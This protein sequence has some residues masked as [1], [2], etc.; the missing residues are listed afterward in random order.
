MISD[1]LQ[2][3]L[4]P[5]IQAE[6]LL[7]RQRATAIAIGASSLFGL[8]YWIYHQ[9]TESG[10][11]AVTLLWLG[12]TA[13]LLIGAWAWANQRPAN[14]KAIARRLEAEY[15]ELDGAL[16]TAV[17]QDE[18]EGHQLSYLQERVVCEA[19]DHSVAHA[20]TQRYREE[21][22]KWASMF[23]GISLL[24]FIAVS[25]L[26][27]S[28]SPRSG[29]DALTPT[30]G[31]P[32][33]LATEISVTPG[34]TEV[35]KG[36]KL[37]VEARFEGVVPNEAAIELVSAESD[38]LLA[39]IPMKR[40]MEDP[41]YGAVIPN[42][43]EPV[44]Y[45]IAYPNEASETFDI[46]IYVHPELEN[47]DVTI[48]PPKY[49]KL[50]TKTLKDV[51]KV[52]ALE[53]S[54]LDF[55]F[56]INKEVSDAELFGEDGEIIPL[57]ADPEDP[58]RLT[59][60]FRPEK[61]KK[62]RLHLVDSDERA[63]KT[64][65]WFTVN[66]KKNQL[67]K[68]ELAFPGKDSEVSALE[69]MN[70]EGK[71]WD[72]LGIQR[73]GASITVGEES[74]EVVL[75]GEPLPGQK[76]H[77]FATL[78]ALE[79][80]GAEPTELVSYHFWAED[81]GPD[82]EPRRVESDMFFA[83]VR[84]WEHI[85]RE[86][87]QQGGQQQ[88]QQGQQSQSGQLRMQQKEIMNA[89]WKVARRA[90]LSGIAG[91]LEDVQVIKTAQETVATNVDMVLQQVQDPTLAETLKEAQAKMMEAVSF[92]DWVIQKSDGLRM[93]D[94]LAAEKSAYQ[95]LLKAESRES[96]VTRSQSSSSSGQSQ[97]Q[98]RQLMQLDLKE[99]ENRYET[100]RQ[101]Q[102]EQE[103][104][105]QQ[106]DLAVLNRLKELAR[107]EQALAEKIKE[108]EAALEEAKTE[109][110]RKELERQLE[111]LQEEQEELLRDVDDLMERM[112]SEENQERMGEER[113]KLAETR[114][115]IQEA[116][117]QLKNNELSEA[118][119]SATRAQQ[120]MD[121]LRE[122]F[123]QRTSQRFAEELRELRQQARDLADGQEEIGEQ[124]EDV[125]DPTNPFS[126]Q[127]SEFD[128][129]EVVQQLRDQKAE[130]QKLLE[131]MQQVSEQAEESE[132]VLSN[133][134][135]ETVRE[136]R[137]NGADEA[138]DEASTYTRYGNLTEAQKMEREAGRAIEKLKEGV[139]RAAET[140]LGDEA[141]ALRMA[142]NELD[143][144][145]QALEE[146]RQRRAGSDPN[147][148]EPGTS[149]D[150]EQQ[151]QNMEGTPNQPGQEGQQPGTDPQRGQQPGQGQQPSPEQ[152]AQNDRQPGKEPNAQGQGQQPQE[153]QEPSQGQ[154]PSD[155]PGQG[156]TQEG[157]QAGQGQGQMAENESGE[158]SDQ[159]G[160][161]FIKR[162]M[163]ESA[164][165]KGEQESQQ[166]GQQPGDGQQ[167]GQQGLQGQEGQ[168]QG[169]QGQSQMAQGQSGQQPGQGQSQGQQG[170]PGQ[171]Q[172]GQQPGTPQ[173]PQ[174]SQS[175]VAQGGG[176][177]GGGGSNFF[178]G[179]NWDDSVGGASNQ[180]APPLFFDQI[181]QA[182]DP[183][184]LMGEDY[185]AFADS[186]RKVEDVLE[187]PELRS[188]ASKVLDRARSMRI[189]YRRNDT[190][191]QWDVVSETII[192][193][194]V[195]LRDLVSEEL[196]RTEQDDSLVP[197]DR[198]P[199]PGPYRDLVRKYYEK[200]A[201]GE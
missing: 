198:D 56:K 11:A 53:G 6:K 183:G 167:P 100:E 123:R 135:Y 148:K 90:T 13:A 114:E 82:G 174:P 182:R 12:T 29:S 17:E 43:D 134:L 137:I 44:R 145:I 52:T 127:N 2:H 176:G 16:V 80:F 121:E 81:L 101:A 151:A 99:D 48:S 128:R 70:L 102:P 170:Q 64:P 157:E 150:Q 188:Q 5:L 115:K 31:S 23:Q 199:V 107:R 60:K 66:L 14:L 88:G 15:P 143:S 87:T 10:S 54:E 4:S 175:Q 117:E 28:V 172:G 185:E 108:I 160:K 92:L 104:T 33:G 149:P 58:T 158:E 1:I 169:E 41:A 113:E 38:E 89:T 46:G 147:A 91:Q 166:P 55:A 30:A 109:E 39:S 177:G 9:Q 98:Q 112:E 77:D 103:T 173:N 197:I 67:P 65:P 18:D 187:V 142:R 69:E 25:L 83:E 76:K 146:E 72:D 190:P 168:G 196:A 20:W 120:E 163:A 84:H 194:L 140:V 155:Q 35:E 3:R 111:R 186:L 74:R 95:L 59:A 125:P 126:E 180:T 171:Q 159:Q 71:V 118:A 144:A 130:L 124:F 49:A 110:E 97:Q 37:V 165:Q 63:N 86:G 116:N 161:G 27:I 93:E 131:N 164:S 184:V 179:D 192:D 141:Q 189:D 22:R 34:T 94:A 73:I 136:A 36:S 45:R 133:S 24:A 195:E 122:D 75:Q 19:V 32:S 119:N 47:A 191:P 42:I 78:L 40:V 21:Q 85:F 138:L 178:G 68:M 57:I 106:E 153:G 62:Y 181:D 8:C 139:E 50:E 105:P 79:E 201:S 7:R 51:R 96:Q 193:P 26:V 129:M 132:P 156:Q 154:Q 61:E 200:L 162:F 152:L